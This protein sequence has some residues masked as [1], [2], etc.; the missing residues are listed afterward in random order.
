MKCL[1]ADADQRIGAREE[2]KVRLIAVS[3]ADGKSLGRGGSVE[4]KKPQ[5]LGWG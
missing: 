4:K 1:E 2:L 5:G 3:T